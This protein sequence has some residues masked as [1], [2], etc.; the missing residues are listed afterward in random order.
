MKALL[1]VIVACMCAYSWG[2][3]KTESEYLKKFKDNIS[4]YVKPGVRI[5]GERTGFELEF[6]SEF[7]LLNSRKTRVLQLAQKI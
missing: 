1:I 3:N 7:C 4:S 2:A 6:Q 5:I